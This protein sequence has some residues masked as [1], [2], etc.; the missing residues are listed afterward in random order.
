[1]TGRNGRAIAA[2]FITFLLLLVSTGTALHAESRV[3]TLTDSTSENPVRRHIEIAR[4]ASEG[5]AL[6]DIIEL[7]KSSFVDYESAHRSFRASDTRRW[8]RLIIVNRSQRRDWLFAFLPTSPVT[9][10]VFL[11][12]SKGGYVH[13]ATSANADF[14]ERQIEHR[15]IVYPVSFAPGSAETVYFHM[16]PQQIYSMGIWSYDGFLKHSRTDELLLGLFYGIAIAIT[17][18]NLFLFL[19]LRDTAYLYYSLFLLVFSTVQ[20]YRD[21]TA[22]EYL[23]F[24]GQQGGEHLAMDFFANFTAVWTFL[25]VRK[26]LNIR[27]YSRFLDRVVLCLTLFFALFSVLFFFVDNPILTRISTAGALPGL[28]VFLWAVGA[29]VRRGFRPARYLLY[30]MAP[31]IVTT[32]VF[33]LRNMG[34]LV[35]WAI[36]VPATYVSFA[37]AAI[38]FSLA[39]ADRISVIGEER[40]RSERINLA[41]TEFFV[42]LSHE[43]KT[44]LTIISNY[45]ESYIANHGRSEELEV[46]RRAVSKLTRDMN[47]F[48]DVLRFEKGIEVYS[49]WALCDVSKIVG[50]RLPLFQELCSTRG[51]T[52]ESSVQQ[53]LRVTADPTALDRVLDNLFEN[54]VR[55]NRPSG[56]IAMRLFEGEGRALL[57]VSDSGVGIA[58]EELSEIFKP[59]Y[60]VSQRKHGNQGIG[61]G[62]N[63]VRNIVDSIGGSISV[64]SEL[65]IGSTFTVSLPIAEKL[66][67]AD[68]GTVVARSDSLSVLLSSPG[69]TG[70]Q[71]TGATAETDPLR[72]TILVVE[73]NAELLQLMASR[74]SEHY[75]VLAAANGEEALRLLDHSAASCALV[76]TDI[77]MDRI[78]GYELLERLQQDPR[79]EGIPCIFV[80]AKSSLEERVRGLSRGAIDYLYKPFSVDELLVKVGS[81]TRHQRLEKERTAREQ[82]LSMRAIVA[83]FSHEIGNPLNAMVASIGNLSRHL[84]GNELFEDEKVKKYVVFL[85]QSVERIQEVASTL[86]RLAGERSYSKESLELAPLLDSVVEQFDAAKI[87]GTEVS[88][89]IERGTTIIGDRESV[90]LVFRN[91]LANAFDAVAERGKVTIEARSNSS[92]ALVKVRDNGSGMDD[93]VRNRIFDPFFTTKETGRGEGLGLFLVGRACSDMGWHIEVSSRPDVG[94]EVTL[95]IPIGSL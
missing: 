6:N 71:E 50:E 3:L 68:E 54:A 72:L 22:T 49:Q 25:F 53:G 15:Y 62:L 27:Q 82:L 36:V 18:Y 73:D 92:H 31:A 95:T 9:S 7:D 40:R 59:Y 85:R 61:M 66:G 10:D 8:F 51:I 44:P 35:D 90:R 46:M 42:N 89:R 24:L 83:G 37:V 28:A 74:L 26:F 48:F 88:R 70:A 45:L 47:Q 19:R 86:R 94:T 56:R 87:D 65:G 1:M 41:K 69:A 64:E 80:S 39:L 14:S 30:G 60:Q 32:A 84:K 81:L 33:G 93:E 12:D 5:L 21:G 75:R 58:R 91:L 67:P 16:V 17:F 4:N 38:L 57:E 2:F 77:M 76:I 34:F 29:A 55:Y 13:H 23:R 78:D 63:L 52:F 43:V 20:A 79:Y 11:P